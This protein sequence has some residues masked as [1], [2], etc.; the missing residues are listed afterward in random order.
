MHKDWQDWDNEEINWQ[1]EA[2]EQEQHEEWAAAV[3]A[4]EEFPPCI[5]DDVPDLPSPHVLPDV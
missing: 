2:Y 3:A 5:P 4:G 1:R